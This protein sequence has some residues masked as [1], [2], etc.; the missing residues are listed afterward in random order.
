MTAFLLRLWIGCALA[1]WTAAAL[2]TGQAG[3]HDERRT[4]EPALLTFLYEEPAADALRPLHAT[5]EESGILESWTGYVNGL[6]KPLPKAVNVMFAECGDANS[7]Y[8]PEQARIVLCYEEAHRSFAVLKMLPYDGETLLLTAWVGALL[9]QLYH[10]LAHALVHL[11]ALPVLG[12]EE[13]AADQFAVV[14]LLGHPEGWNLLLGA[15]EYFREL[16]SIETEVGLEPA[17]PHPFFSQRY[18][19]ILCLTYGSDTEKHRFVVTEGLLPEA[20]AKTCRVEYVRAVH[21]WG[22]LLEP[23]GK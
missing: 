12:R 13:D 8:D 4:R 5:L 17:G 16:A 21:G 19:N 3:P 18:Y 7:R 1:T 20:R 6:L 11:L 9:H 10:E 2:P 22:T 15:A 14:A 23:F